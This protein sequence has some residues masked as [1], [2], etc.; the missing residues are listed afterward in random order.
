MLP[1]ARAKVAS[2]SIRPESGS[3]TANASPPDRKARSPGRSVSRRS[4]AISPMRSSVAGEPSR[5]FAAARSSMSRT[6]TAS[7]RPARWARATARASV[8][9]SSWRVASPVSTSVVG[10]PR[11]AS[12]RAFSIAGPAC[13]AMASSV[14]NSAPATG[15]SSSVP[16]TVRNPS[17]AVLGFDRDRDRRQHLPGR[18]ALRRGSGTRARR[19]GRPLLPGG[20]TAAPTVSGST[21]TAA[22]NGLPSISTV[23]AAAATP[24]SDAAASAAPRSGLRRGRAFR[25]AMRGFVPSLRLRGPSQPPPRAPARGCR[26]GRSWPGD[27][28]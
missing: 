19:H 22:T 27:P 9:W 13:S 1:V 14:R 20:P 4:A 28:V 12:P 2:A 24:R 7:F 5:V 11:A 17:S 6:Q 21:P 18:G 23:I 16:K 26:V 10:A 8:S 25:R 15:G 3:R